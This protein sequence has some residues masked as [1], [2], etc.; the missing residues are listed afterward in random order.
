MMLK[1]GNL[2]ST[3]AFLPHSKIACT[4]M[5]KIKNFSKLD[6]LADEVGSQ[7]VRAADF[8]HFSRCSDSPETLK[9]GV[10]K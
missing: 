5:Q 4:G 10:V 7:I 8:I 1:V 6:I 9:F 2:H 3:V